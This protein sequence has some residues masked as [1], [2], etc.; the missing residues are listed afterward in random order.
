MVSSLICYRRQLRR[1][2]VLLISLERN[3]FL[4]YDFSSRVENFSCCEQSE[5]FF[6]KEGF[7]V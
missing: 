7:V 3:P 4:M 1:N 6:T 5:S 2:G